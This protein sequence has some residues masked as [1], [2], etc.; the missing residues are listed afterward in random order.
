MKPQC[1]DGRIRQ[2]RL[3]VQI[4][5]GEWS[6]WNQIA[7]GEQECHNTNRQEKGFGSFG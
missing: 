1:G 7:K 6:E 2:Q 3:L 4:R 5:G